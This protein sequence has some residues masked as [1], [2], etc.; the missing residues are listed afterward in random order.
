MIFSSDKI[1]IVKA[2]RYVQFWAERNARPRNAI[3]E[4]S[5]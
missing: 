2:A 4:L 5:W 3:N 1:F